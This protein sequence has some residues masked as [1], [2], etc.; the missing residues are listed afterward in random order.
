MVKVNFYRGIVSNKVRFQHS[1]R[2]SK[3]VVN[4]LLLHQPVFG[5]C[6]ID[7][8]SPSLGERQEKKKKTPRSPLT[9]VS[10]NQSGIEN[11]LKVGKSLFCVTVVFLFVFFG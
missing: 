7:C 4:F 1:K 3:V 5:S 11:A 6:P 9:F 8:F 10:A 2:L